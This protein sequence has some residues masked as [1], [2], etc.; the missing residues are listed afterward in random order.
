MRLLNGS[1]NRCGALAFA[2]YHEIAIIR[3][4]GRVS[5]TTEFALPRSIGAGAAAMR[6]LDGMVAIV[7]G[8]APGNM[9]A[10]TAVRLAEEDATVVV[11]DLNESAAR[12]V[13][14]EIRELDG[15]A[16]A[17]SFDITDE[18]SYE[19]LI[20][21]T[22]NEFSRVDGLLNVAGDVSPGDMGHD[23]DVISVPVDLWRHIIDVTLTGYMYGI[24]H[25]LPVMIKQGGG[26][27]VNAVST[28][29]WSASDRHV[30]Y[31]VA[32]AGLYGLTRH[33]AMLGGK[34][35]VRCNSVAAGV[36]LTRAVLADTTEEWRTAILASVRSP[37]LG[38]PED[39]AAM[40]AFLLS[41]DA[42]YVNGQT[43]HV[44]GGADFD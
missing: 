21:F 13:V 8:A 22:V 5:G 32:N 33:T 31:Q 42:A 9:G 15:R 17:Q 19:A 16:T 20:D 1:T 41:D 12:A 35:G 40:V 10:A 7:A 3:C 30:A 34:H 24:R 14:A 36:I 43:L 2:A 44:D 28:S 23:H 37:R 39:I 26:A 38:I 29:V 18:A 25:V 4:V 6:G 27:I 11:A